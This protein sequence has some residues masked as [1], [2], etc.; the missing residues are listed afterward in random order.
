MSQYIQFVTD[1]RRV[2]DPIRLLARART[3][4]S[5]REFSQIF[6]LQVVQHTYNIPALVKSLT[7]ET[8]I[9]CGGWPNEYIV[10]T[11]KYERPLVWR[12]DHDWI[13]IPNPVTR[14]KWF[15]QKEFKAAFEIFFYD[16]IYQWRRRHE[17]Q[18]VRDT[19]HRDNDRS[20]GDQNGVERLDGS[21]IPE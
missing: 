14:A 1:D 21:G 7:D 20:N 8:V 6:N 15:E 13:Y 10:D 5:N 2:V 12:R 9:L 17:I 16:L 18:N 19:G 11:A 3:G 4:V